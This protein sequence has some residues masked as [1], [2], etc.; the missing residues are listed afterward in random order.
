MG[1]TFAIEPGI[2]I[3]CIPIQENSVKTAQTSRDRLPGAREG[4]QTGNDTEFRG[5]KKRRGSAPAFNFV[6]SRSYFTPS[7][8]T[9]KIR[10][11]FGGITPPA[12][13]AP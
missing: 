12:P 11:A 1:D 8:S 13:R 6:P 4:E 5:K 2:D 3:K 9:S 10:V 7:T